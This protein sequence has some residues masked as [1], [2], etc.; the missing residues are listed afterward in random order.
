MSFSSVVVGEA[1]AGESGTG[2]GDAGNC[3][4][5]GGASRGEVEAS[6]G[7]GGTCS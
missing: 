5:E 6:K 3:S 1:H 2:S 4:G 7:E